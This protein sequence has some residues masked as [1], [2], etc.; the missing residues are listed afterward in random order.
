MKEINVGVDIADTIIDVWPEL[1]KKQKYITRIILII[2]G[3]E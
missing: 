1:M 3:V 2:Q